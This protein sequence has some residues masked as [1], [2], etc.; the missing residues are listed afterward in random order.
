MLKSHKPSYK[1]GRTSAWSSY[2]RIKL[3]LHTLKWWGAPFLKSLFWNRWCKP[4]GS[5]LCF[6]AEW[7]LVNGLLLLLPPLICLLSLVTSFWQNFCKLDFGKHSGLTWAQPWF[8]QIPNIYAF[9]RPQVTKEHS[10]DCMKIQ[11]GRDLW[12]VINLYDD[13]KI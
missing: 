2:W 11:N 13:A 6:T 4:Q 5:I 12:K 1:L 9:Y 3:T 8:H 10:H 7:P